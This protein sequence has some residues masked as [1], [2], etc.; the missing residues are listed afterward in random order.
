MKLVPIIAL[1]T[2]EHAREVARL[3]DDAPADVVEQMATACEMYGWEP[4]MLV[5]GS[6]I[7]QAIDAS[8]ADRA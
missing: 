1:V 8:E 3:V 5:A 2:P 7:R 4:A 6:I